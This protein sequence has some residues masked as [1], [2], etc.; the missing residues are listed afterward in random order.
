MI[1]FCKKVK[2]VIMLKIRLNN[3]FV[4]FYN[5]IIWDTILFVIKNTYCVTYFKIIINNSE[6]VVVLC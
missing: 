1:N 4:N 3:A 2:L 5:E 6:M